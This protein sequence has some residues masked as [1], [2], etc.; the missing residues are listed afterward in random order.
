MNTGKLFFGLFAIVFGLGGCV[1]ADSTPYYDDYY[2]GG[3]VSTH[4]VYHHV[5]PP[6]QDKHHHVTPTPQ[7][8]H[9]RHV[10]E[11]KQD[12]SVHKQSHQPQKDTTKMKKK[13]PSQNALT[14][15]NPVKRIKP[16]AQS[17]LPHRPEEINKKK[18]S[19][20][21]ENRPD[22]KKDPKPKK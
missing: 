16:I 9:H 3:Y 18:P 8:K 4:H 20:A 19:V 21:P 11:K 10:V 14:S 15:K 5:T 22:P 13:T 6:P 17:K 7:D 1:I 12:K 2:D